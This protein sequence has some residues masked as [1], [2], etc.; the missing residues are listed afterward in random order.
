MKIAKVEV[1]QIMACN[2]C[3]PIDQEYNGRFVSASRD[4]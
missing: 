1:V 2:K 4:Q 3:H